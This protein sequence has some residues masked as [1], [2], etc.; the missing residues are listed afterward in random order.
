MDNYCEDDKCENN[1][2]CRPLFRDY[3]CECL[4]DS[5]SGERCEIVAIKIKIYRIVSK[6]FAYVAIIALI[7]VAMFIVIMDILKY[8]FGIDPVEIERERMRRQKQAKKRKP[9]IQRFIYVNAP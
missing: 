7:I 1:G 4:G 6:S 2:V 8:C 9:F 5:F 3:R